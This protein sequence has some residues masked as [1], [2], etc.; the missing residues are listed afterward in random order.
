MPEPERAGAPGRGGAGGRTRRSGPAPWELSRR[1][2][3]TRCSSGA[4]SRH[5]LE[6]KRDRIPENACLEFI[7][8]R[9]VG[10][11][12]PADAMGSRR[13][14]RCPPRAGARAL[15]TIDFGE[16]NKYYFALI[17][18]IN[19]TLR[20]KEIYI[21]IDWSPRSPRTARGPPVQHG[22]ERGL[23][24]KRRWPPINEDLH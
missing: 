12:R 7:A 16:L 14:G 21:Y 2:S 1:R 23:A 13:K 6:S 18:G 11:P 9:G 22:P 15:I 8:P 17:S 24:S 10:I 20:E 19:K 5:S 4:T 3:P